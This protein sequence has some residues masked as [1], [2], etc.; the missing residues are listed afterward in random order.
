MNDTSNENIQKEGLHFQLLLYVNIVLGDSSLLL[1]TVSDN[2]VAC[3][4]I[5]ICFTQWLICGSKNCCS[6]S[7][8]YKFI[9]ISLW[10]ITV[11]LIPYC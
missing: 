10:L 9:N 3:T 7:V 4:I 2:K 8:H 6:I 11:C 1:S 5:L